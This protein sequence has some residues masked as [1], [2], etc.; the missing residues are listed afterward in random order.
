M[1]VSQWNH[2]PSHRAS[3][4]R[5]TAVAREQLFG[6][7]I[8]SGN[9]I[10]R[11]NGRDVFYAVRARATLNLQKYYYYY[12]YYYYYCVDVAIARQRH[13]KHVSATTDM[14]TTK[15]ERLEAVFS[16]WSVQRVYNENQSRR[17]EHGSRIISTPES[18]YLAKTSE[19]TEYFVC[20]VITVIFG[21][22]KPVRLL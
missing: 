16:M 9:D 18:C 22:S 3:T 17:R 4:C 5:P 6:H 13:V 15:E 7:I 12:Y 10:T 21:V 2:A 20:A 8:S 19:D 11:N 1:D 14:Y